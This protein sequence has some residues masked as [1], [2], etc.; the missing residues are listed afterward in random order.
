VRACTSQ[1]RSEI[2]AARE[3]SRTRSYAL[4]INIQRPL[5]VRRRIRA[6]SWANK[7]MKKAIHPSSCP[8]ASTLCQCNS[9][10]SVMQSLTLCMK[11]SNEL[12]TD[13]DEVLLARQQ[14]E[15]VDVP[16]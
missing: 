9:L 13:N 10:V 12:S 2:K 5:R 14:Q 1:P 11:A 7:I 15:H 6:A 4:V 3:S 16:H 8:P